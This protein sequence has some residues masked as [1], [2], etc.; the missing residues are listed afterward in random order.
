[1]ETAAACLPRMSD[2]ERSA[3]ERDGFVRL[4]GA[5]PATWVER[6]RALALSEHRA[7]GER[8]RLNLHD[9]LARDQA[10]LELVDWA[11]AFARVWGVLGWNIQCYH[12]QLV[13]TPPHPAGPPAAWGWHQDNNRMGRDLGV[14]LQPRVSVKLF[15]FLTDCGA[16]EGS[17]AVVPGSH[18]TR[19]LEWDERTR[20]PVGAV[21]LAGRAGEAVLFDRRLWH[22]GAPNHGRETR[23]ALYYGYSHRWLRPKCAMRVEPWMEGDPVRRQLLGHASSPNGRYEPLDEDVPLRAWIRTNHGDA[24]VA[25]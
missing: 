22:A 6:L 2:E 15:W 14:E 20:Q 24:A 18:R 17:L 13:C 1:M 3:F 12:T 23:L 10:F 25:P 19:G 16:G 8:T 11:P 7:A 9:L 5:L 4:P 21:E